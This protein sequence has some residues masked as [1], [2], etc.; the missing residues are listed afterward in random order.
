VLTDSSEV[1]HKKQGV[2]PQNKIS[3]ALGK[4]GAAA[5]TLYRRNCIEQGFGEH[6]VHSGETATPV[7]KLCGASVK[8]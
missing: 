3:A 5:E 1:S 4:N 7:H 8:V 6:V 2:F